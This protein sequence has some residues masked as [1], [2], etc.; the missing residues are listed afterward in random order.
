MPVPPDLFA[1]ESVF[2]AAGKAALTAA[3]VSPAYHARELV[4]LPAARVVVEASGFARA[5]GHMA[6]DAQRQ[7]FY[8]HRGFRLTYTITTPRTAEGVARHDAWLASIR[9][10]HERPRQTFAALPYKLIKLEPS[11][12]S[13]TY[14]QEGERDRSELIWEGELGIPGGL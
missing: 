1:F 10:L 12:S 4:D 14:I 13:L 7:P 11:D 5:S 2:H 3:G 8:D 6:F 9:A